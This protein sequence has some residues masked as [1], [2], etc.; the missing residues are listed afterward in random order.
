MNTYFAFK[1]KLFINISSSNSMVYYSSSFSE[2]ALVGL[3][4]WAWNQ[5]EDCKLLATFIFQY[6]Y[7]PVRD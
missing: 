1:I 2:L 7:T 6:Q 4:A 5:P 3:T